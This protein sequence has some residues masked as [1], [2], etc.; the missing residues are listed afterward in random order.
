M[1]PM[2]GITPLWD[3]KKGDIRMNPN[4]TRALEE[5][6]AKVA[7]RPS[8]VG[9]LLKEIYTNYSHNRL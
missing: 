9:V 1:K 4:Y 7:D 8:K 6:G 2:I 5:A 3:A